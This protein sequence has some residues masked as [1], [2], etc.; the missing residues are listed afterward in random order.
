MSNINRISKSPY[1]KT[2]LK[3]T[4]GIFF[5]FAVS[6]ITWLNLQP[7]NMM[8][9][10]VIAIIAV[11]ARIIIS[12]IEIRRTLAFVDVLTN[13]LD[14]ACSGHIYTR[15]TNTK[16]L[17]EIGKTAW[18]LNDFMDIVEAYFKETEACFQAVAKNDF[19]RRPFT[20]GLPKYFK[21]SLEG[22]GRSIEVMKQVD[23]VTQQNHLSSDLH[24]LNTENLLNNLQI[25]QTDL[26]KISDDIKQINQLSKQNKDNTE[27][28]ARQVKMMASSTALIQDGMKAAQSSLTELSSSQVDIN[29]AMKMITD[30]TDQ[31][32]LLALNAAIEAARA[33]EAGR[34]F[35]VVADEVKALSNKTKE[36]A[37]NISKNLTTFAS[38]M[39]QVTTA[40]DNI[41]TS[42]EQI[43]ESIEEVEDSVN[44]AEETSVSTERLVSNSEN[45]IY[46]SLIKIDHIIY[47]QHAYRA[48]NNN[49]HTASV[50][51]ISTDHHQCR[52]GMWYDK[53]ETKESFS[54]NQSYAELDAPHAI[55]HASVKIAL[56]GAYAE[57][58]DQELVVNEMQKTEDASSLLIEKL[59]EM[60]KIQNENNS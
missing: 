22:I 52:M 46:A 47:K 56:E 31:T 14:E 17:G 11:I 58:I 24:Q 8:L 57:E 10:S 41:N 50:N 7:E 34:G 9:I 49:E 30:I 26:I 54:K 37:L 53:P 32:T 44:R 12:Q 43:I 21:T 3:I 2:R 20:S 5:I 36:T 35:A 45:Q 19:S 4:D 38:S 42:S 55:V 16:N 60:V 27:V 33:G 51:A 48:L 1:L 29:D 6:M 25:S 18:A 39:Q 13:A 59:S 23:T 40:F 15:I 28:S